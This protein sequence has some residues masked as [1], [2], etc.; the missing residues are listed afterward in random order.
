MNLYTFANTLIASLDK[1]K[2]DPVIIVKPV[3]GALPLWYISHRNYNTVCR[4][5]SLLVIGYIS[6]AAFAKH[7]YHSIAVAIRHQWWI[8]V[9]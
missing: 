8:F 7:S 4:P 3:R 1:D 5:K 9:R 6:V 2:P